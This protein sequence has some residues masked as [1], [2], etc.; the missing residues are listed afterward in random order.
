MT[1]T[2]DLQLGYL[3]KNTKTIGSLENHKPLE[4][5]LA[6]LLFNLT[7]QSTSL[8]CLCKYSDSM[9]LKIDIITFTV[10]L[11]TLLRTGIQLQYMDK[12]VHNKDNKLSQVEQEIFWEILSCKHF[13]VP[14][15]EVKVTL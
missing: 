9:N 12:R 4:D 15:R 11:K 6:F 5:Y 1:A 14:D 8:Y 10:N 13:W 7:K 2:H 3:L